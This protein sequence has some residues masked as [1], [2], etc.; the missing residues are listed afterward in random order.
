MDNEK[1]EGKPTKTREDLQTMKTVEIVK[2]EK[3][4]FVTR[5]YY[6]RNHGREFFTSVAPANI[7]KKKEA[8]EFLQKVEEAKEKYINDW[9]N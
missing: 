7:K 4:C 9:I 5:R 3:G 8:K 1:R 6:D 2:T